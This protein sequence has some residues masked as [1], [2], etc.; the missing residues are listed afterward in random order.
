MLLTTSNT[1]NFFMSVIFC[2]I[3]GL[4][5]MALHVIL[6]FH[7]KCDANPLATDCLML[8]YFLIVGNGT[9]FNKDLV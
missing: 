8:M 9:K 5:P 3:K 6:F 7:T 2:V 4:V 1:E